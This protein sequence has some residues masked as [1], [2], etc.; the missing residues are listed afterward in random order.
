M[1]ATLA[2]KAVVYPGIVAWAGILALAGPGLVGCSGE[3]DSGNINPVNSH[4]D[5]AQDAGSH[6][7]GGVSYGVQPVIYKVT[8]ATGPTAGGSVVAIQGAGFREG[9]RVSF[10]ESDASLVRFLDASHLVAVAPLGVAGV[11]DLVV[12]DPAG[13]Q[14]VFHNGF[15]YYELDASAP[16]PPAPKI[17]LPVPN[18]GP[19]AGGTA[20]MIQGANFQPDA[21]VFFDWRP[22]PAVVVA[23]DQVL[24]FT[25]P[26]VPAGTVD[27]AVT[28]PDGQSD[29][30]EKAFA[31]Y[32]G[33]DQGPTITQVHP[34]GGSAEG[35][36]E[37][38]LT[39]EGFVDD[40][41]LLLDGVPVDSWQV[42]SPTQATFV[43]PPHAPG[44]ASLTVTNP[45]GQSARAPDAFLFF[46]D[47]PVVHAVAPPAGPVAGGNTITLRGA[48]LADGLKAWLGGKPCTSVSVLSST[49]A[50]CVAPAG[51]APGP[52]P[53]R[54]ENPDGLSGDLPDAYS[55]GDDPVLSEVEP[56]TGPT[57]GGVLVVLH[58][59]NLDD[60]LDVYFGDA[61]ATLA[62]ASPQALTVWLPPGIEGP[63]D[64]RLV[65]DGADLATLPGAFAY[66]AP[67]QPQGAEL[68]LSQVVP[69]AGPTTGG[70]AQLKGFHFPDP[71]AVTLGTVPATDVTVVSSTEI[72]F[73]VPPADTPGA[74]TVTVTD[75]AT[76]LSGSLQQGYLYLDP[77]T[78]TEPAPTVSSLQPSVG[79]VTGGTQ[80]QL[81]GTNLQAGTAV[82]LGGLPTDVLWRA[83]DGTRLVFRTPSGEEGPVPLVL[84][85]PL[86]GAAEKP[87]AFSYLATTEPNPLSLGSAAPSQ[88][89]VAGGTPVTVVGAGFEPGLQLFLDDIPVASTLDGPTSLHF[90]A[91][92]HAPGLV[93]LTATTAD[94]WTA[95][96]SDA[97]NFVLQ[98]PF[99]GQ[100]TP[101]TG[102]TAGGYEVTLQGQGFHPQATVT[103]GGA[104]APVT[105]DPA[106]TGTR[107]TITVPASPDGAEGPVDVVVTNPDGLSNTLAG[108]FT[109]SDA[110]TG[111]AVTLSQITPA[112]APMD[113]PTAVTVHGSG[114]ASGASLLVGTALAS[115]V[116]V[117]SDD[118]LTALVPAS[119]VAGPKDVQVVV[120]ALGQ[121]TLPAAFF[122]YDPVTPDPL[123]VILGVQPATGPTAGGTVA[124][125]TVLPAHPD[126]HVYV[127]GLPVE[128]LGA[129]GDEALLVRMPAH[130][131][132]V[133]PV[134]VSYPDGK[135]A[136][137]P[138]AFA[139]Y[140][141]APDVVPPTLSAVTPAQGSALG[142]DAVTLSGGDLAPGSVVFFGSRPA[143]V[144][145]GSLS[146]SLDAL[147]VVTPA[148]PV[149]QV[150]VTVTRPDGLS[151]T[152]PG[153]FAFG[154]PDP[155]IDDVFP[156]V[157]DV[158]G[159]LTVA[160]AGANFGA[161]TQVFF[162]G[163]PAT[164]VVVSSAHVL[165]ARTPAA[166]QPG[167]VDVQVVNASGQSTTAPGAFTYTDD[168][169]TTSPPS[170]L[171]LVP[172]VGPPAGGTVLVVYGADFQPGALAL[173]NGAPAQVHVVEPSWLTVTTPAGLTG[174]VDV[175]VVN[176]DGQSTTQGSAFTYT[177]VAAPA[178]KLYSVTP[179]QGPEAGDTP[180]IL[181]GDALTGGGVGFVGYRP[182]SSWTVLNSVIATGRTAAQAPDPTQGADVVV[183]NGD[184]QS[185]TLP[186]AYVFVGAPAID[187]FD[188]TAGPVAGGQTVTLAGRNFTEGCQVTFGGEASPAVSVQSPFVITAQT[189]PGAGAGPAEVR[190]SCAD[191]QTGTAAQP[192]VYALPPA[193]ASLF[194][195]QGAAAGG[196]PLI[197][198]GEGFLPGATVTLGDA[199]ATDV[200]VVDAQTL[201]ARAPAGDAGQTVDVRVDNPDGQAGVLYDAYTFVD[202]AQV[203]AAPTLSAV[204]P[205]S[206]PT[207]GGTWGLVQGADMR[208]GARALFGAAPAAAFQ[209]L[210]VAQGAAG[211]RARFVSPAA[212][213]AGP[214]EV[215]VVNPDGSYGTL[216]GGFAFVDPATLG[217]PPE[218]TSLSPTAGPTAGGT[219]VGLTGTA[220]SG[221]TLVFFDTT[222]ALG[223]AWADPTLTLTTPAHE[224]GGVD[225]VVTHADGRTVTLPASYTFVSPPTLEG[226]SPETGPATG[227]TVVTLTGQDFVAG[228]TAAQ[229]SRVLLCTDFAASQGCVQ[230]PF[231]DTT[232]AADGTA[233]TFTAPPTTPGLLDVAVVNPD[234]QSDALL[235]AF[236]S[237]PPPEIQQVS[238]SSGSTLGGTALTLTG[239]GF[240]TGAVV[241]IGGAPCEDVQ[242]ADGLSITCT[243]PPGAPGPAAV[244]VTNTDGTTGTLAGGF[245]YLAPPVISDVWP[246]M[247]PEAGGDTMTIQGSGFVPGAG[248]SRVRLGTTLVPEADTVV[249]SETVIQLTIP[250]GQGLVAVE[251]DNP[252]GQKAVLA[253]GFLYL[254]PTPP[255]VISY[256]TPNSGST[257]GG[258]AVSI[259]GTGFQEAAQVELSLDGAT[260]VPAS[261]GTVEVKN[262][263]TLITAVTPPSG[264]AG[265]ADVR[266]TNTDGQSG[267]APQAFEYVAPAG[268]PE[269]AFFQITPQRGP[270]AGGY[271]V[272]IAGQGFF[273]DV[274]VFF[275]DEAAGTWVQAASVTRLGP[276]LLRVTVPAYP[277]TGL[278]DVR[279]VNTGLF[280]PPDEV[281]A[282]DVFTF[283]QSV[284]WELKGHRA[285][286]DTTQSDQQA[287]LLDLDGDGLRDVVVLRDDIH[288]P[289]DVL[290]NTRDAQGRAG[291]FVDHT[292]ALASATH[293]ATSSPVVTDADGD[294]DEDVYVWSG[295]TM[296]LYRNDAGKLVTVDS[297]VASSYVREA[298]LGDLNCDGVDD[299]FLARNG[300]NQIWVGAGDGTFKLDG[301]ALPSWSQNSQG[302][303]LADVDLDGDLDILVANETAQQNRLLYNNCANTPLP[304]ACSFD[305]PD[306]TPFE[307]GGHRYVRCDGAKRF[308]DASASCRAH[309]MELATVNDQA[310]QDALVAA[311]GA[312]Q[313]VW[314]GYSDEAQEGT[315]TWTGGE[316]SSF[317][318]WCDGGSNG[319][320]AQ[321]CALMTADVG[322]WNDTYCSASRAYYCEAPTTDLCPQ[323]WGFVDATYGDGKNFPVSGFNS[324]DAVFA[325][326]DDNGFPD[327]I[328]VNYGQPTKVYLNSNG[329]FFNDTGFHFPQ[330]VA[331]EEPGHAIVLDYDR[332]GDWDLIIPR[333]KGTTAW[334]PE[335]YA[336][337]LN[338]AGPHTGIGALS[339]RAQADVFPSWRGPW[340]RSFAVGDLDGDDYPD[341]Y[342][343]SRDQQDWVFLQNGFAD[344]QAMVDANRVGIG[345]FVNSSFEG[346]PED[347]WDTRA[348][349]SGDVNGDGHVDLV[350]AYGGTTNAFH[351]P[352][353]W[354][355]DG[356]G[357]FFEQPGAFPDVSC[358]ARVLKL[359]DLNGDGD[360]DV[361]LGCDGFHGVGFAQL[362]NDGVGHFTDVS[363]QNI[364]D[365]PHCDGMVLADL[366]GDADL[367]VLV[368]GYY[369]TYLWAN[370]KDVLNNDGAYFV[371]QSGVLPSSS[372]NGGRDALIVDLNDDGF[373]DI[374]IARS[375]QNMLW[376]N[377]GSG[378]GSGLGIFVDVT[379]S[380]LPALSDTS[381]GVVVDDVDQDGDLDLF[382]ANDG[383][384]RQYISELDHKYADVTV[385]TVP[386]DMVANSTSIALGD[387]DQ[388]GFKDVITSTWGGPE[389]LLLSQGGASWADFSQDLPQCPDDSRVLVL[390]DFDGDGRPDVFV[391]NTQANRIYM[392][393]TP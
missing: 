156:A 353:L 114:F 214:V 201:T 176:P 329:N 23:S 25:T 371:D 132:G 210:E 239:S 140:E 61:Q 190:V 356:A 223:V 135:S 267:V 143:A 154:T 18:T 205:P 56:S 105:S 233:L 245:V 91:P 6:Q 180:V 374:Y 249:Q 85:S 230:V 117:L 186:G 42:Q 179:S 200:V 273:T 219:Q 327:A 70:W 378:G 290:L 257:L 177:P 128:V 350:M 131:A 296:L 301:A 211:T 351:P 75:P 2:R 293:K 343:V 212:P 93:D 370:G 174:P 123:P 242:V 236:L 281:I 166:S 228:D 367:D 16:S 4:P 279:I 20:L 226:L 96:L 122:H 357:N 165:T 385:T 275:G 391:G 64:V 215:T 375:G 258:T 283:G 284:V 106:P 162:G 315:W 141:A 341:F 130:P 80:V 188:P 87:N 364:P 26:A 358:D 170:V 62:S 359:V 46:V 54:V 14:G 235:G 63:V 102:P 365:Q 372:D 79:P 169:F 10:G 248:G 151:A 86:G 330:D 222:P 319:G 175:T 361:M 145:P 229:S 191:G 111:V 115:D 253:G 217:A 32:E 338:D 243:T 137:L 388:D 360:L 7:D 157:G 354:L 138:D 311:M 298:L 240:Q 158:D 264:E 57:V 24:T 392:N 149:A 182:L 13:P 84:V 204:L 187:S 363:T 68:V 31:V 55:Y 320:A 280:G 35:G 332:D 373:L 345:R 322:C 9:A 337:D 307:H 272:S 342:F 142:G 237:A 58:G 324:R 287:A 12:T 218:V 71:A 60:G 221:E 328:I 181:T 321:D 19:D 129:D 386:L 104:E 380:K 21:T 59:A 72:T 88:G 349:D 74:V 331:T 29:I 206:G 291:V 50:T 255:P 376:E 262:G 220:L 125:I 247:G 193:P 317:E 195:A 185:V 47:P 5:A 270:S 314:I 52:V 377:D 326:L 83:D 159:G 241:T 116:Q 40:S 199:A 28:N 285:A 173:F 110:V 73:R 203:G 335:V 271:D 269:M 389:Q 153:A 119:D 100:V 3:G 209:V 347:V 352:A 39:G 390:D 81:V 196:T 33:D 198:R 362:V 76:G 289:D 163:Q 274:T 134:A 340:P 344:D 303:A 197:L 94:G 17:L 369:R 297:G 133:V 118:T 45:N 265:V 127:A 268:L 168:A 160:L 238:P 393:R 98:P 183:T 184:G 278:V 225:V 109:Y 51:D 384:N 41:F 53:L 121:A 202:A 82:L 95:T 387:V 246:T 66:V 155:V 99:I 302:A 263:G 150:D 231:A 333:K 259:V 78:L 346:L 318:S 213:Q 37:V 178:P 244:V 1:E 266:V 339:L 139:Y 15:E 89:S 27:I 34:V 48:H 112:V 355:N 11:V 77:E 227:G 334:F 136:V 251:V 381:R 252:D 38:T 288:D 146:D 90:T 368:L 101:D 382:V 312:G 113:T 261:Q 97:F 22:V 325:D 65:A 152:L 92:P 216:G 124:L 161:D 120:P 234:G 171:N 299:L 379:M 276:T 8:P 49:E 286:L 310:E 194:P 305:M 316:V 295:N 304:P 250:A 309:G 292:A 313:D 232:V 43:T 67:E 126:A 208:P 30:A 254:P 147:T 148:H 108:G 167:P 383:Q 192:Y 107:L 323:P 294:G 144:Q 366:D 282:S 300:A 306:C 308:G 36:L 207:T 69:A 164:D 260:W 256:V 348:A 44:A 189:P 103:V 336:N 224:A 277:T 172:S